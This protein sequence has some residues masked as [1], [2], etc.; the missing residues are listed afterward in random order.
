[1]TNNQF[2]VIGIGQF[3]EAIAKSLSHLGVEVMAIDIKEERVDYIAGEVAYAV[4]MDAT[5]KKA[6]LSQ[7]IQSFDAVVIAIGDDFE[8]LLLCAVNLIEL[9]VKRIIVRAKGKTSRTILEKLG[10]KEIFSPEADVGALV[11]ERLINP[12]II[13]YLQL[14][15]QYQV[16]ELMPPRRAIGQ[17]IEEL[18][19]RDAYNLSLIT[20]K[21]EIEIDVNGAV[22]S[23]QHIVGVPT[24]NTVVKENDFLVLFGK[25]K[26]IE[27]FIEI[28]G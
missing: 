21:S 25:K 5:D 1:M 28:N 20:I 11:A 3:G 26:D 22:K 13:S 8:Q 18:N 24:S 6:L 27:K 10:L 14:P 2:A 12:N 15:D 9:E 4:A 7:N 17:T 23:E 19:L 16:A